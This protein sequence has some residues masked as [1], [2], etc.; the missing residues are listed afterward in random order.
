M[1]PISN[2]LKDIFASEAVQKVII[3]VNPV[4][5]ESF[6]ISNENI[7]MGSFAIDRATATGNSLELG[8][9][10]ASELSMT[11][12]NDEGTFNGVVWNGAEMIVRVGVEGAEGTVPMGRFY[13]DSTPKSRDTIA[14]SAMD[15]MRKFDKPVDEVALP[16]WWHSKTIEQIVT[17]CCTQC[18]VSLASNISGYPNCS[19]MPEVCPDTKDLT[20][21]QLLIWCCAV[22][23]KCGWMNYDGLLE[24]G[25]STTVSLADT[26]DAS[27]RYSSDYEDSPVEITGIVFSDNNTEYVVGTDDYAFDLSGNELMQ[28]P[29]ILSNLRPLIGLE[30]TPMTVVTVPC[31]HIFPMDWVAYVNGETTYYGLVTN[32]TFSLNGNNAI[33]SAG[34]TPEE[35]SYKNSRSGSVIRQAVAQSSAITESAMQTAVNTASRMIGMSEGGYVILHDADDDG[36]P[37]E[38]LIMDTD[39]INTATKV[40]R[41]NKNGLGYSSTGYSG[42]FGLAMTSNGAIVADYIT[43]G[44]LT[45]D[46]LRAGI[47]RGQQGDSY[48][49]LVT[50]EL[51]IAGGSTVDKSKVFISEPTVPYYEGDLWVTGQYNYSG[52]VGYAIAGYAIAGD[53]TIPTGNGQIMACRYTRTTGSYSSDDWELI[54]NYVDTSEIEILN[55]RITSVEVNVSQQDAKIDAKASSTEVT[56]LGNRITYAELDI[57]GLSGEISSKVSQTDY[58]GNTIASL[59][60]QNATTVQ[61][62]ASKINLTGYVTVSALSGSGT[63]TINGSNITTGSISANRISGGTLTLGGSSNGNGVLNVNNASGSL[64]ARMNNAGLY[65]IAGTIGGYTIGQYTLTGGSGTNAVGICSTANQGWAFWAGATSGNSAPFHVGHNGALYATNATI[66]GSV[67]ATSGTIGGYTIGSSTLRGGSG[68]NTVGMCSTSGQ[69]WAF[70]AGASSGS[71]APFHVGHGGDV[72]CSNLSVT[73][74]SININGTRIDGNGYMYVPNADLAGNF[75]GGGTFGGSLNYATGSFSGSSSGSFSGTGTLTGNSTLSNYSNSGSVII[76]S[77]GSYQ[78]YLAPGGMTVTDGSARTWYGAGSSSSDRKL[79][80][81]I[82]TLDRKRT[83]DFVYSLNPVTFMYKEESKGRHHHGFIAQE[84]QKINPDKKWEIVYS[85]QFEDTECLMIAYQELIADLVATVQSL[86]ERIK[87]LEAK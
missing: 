52:V 53:D 36:R 81:N 55:Q 17:Y 11:L 38:I 75:Y 47:I 67:T 82:T 42:T 26:F 62:Q 48:W 22:M 28:E 5:G 86:N 15:G 46:L 84:V 7:I 43:T 56:E 80:K 71:N 21:R 41:W 10:I 85:H 34:E 4:S 18:E 13:V 6:T 69:E 3:T 65:A 12:L 24:I 49:N 66:T 19:Y 8:S 68:S 39:S 2:T 83:A 57:D 40:W 33:I 78:N 70:W 20:Y 76:L 44:T 50:G 72:H 79:K 77:Y 54:T 31:P 51:H 35:K 63:T 73:G 61:I 29:A 74:G 60:N 58:N 23:G 14:I 64:V 37:D 27:K 87:V 59:I 30:Y 45:A 1:Y 32:Y 9:C 25:F 16:A